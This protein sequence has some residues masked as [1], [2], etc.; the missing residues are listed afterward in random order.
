MPEDSRSGSKLKTSEK[1]MEEPG[2]DQGMRN[3]P[4]MKFY[5]RLAGNL[6]QSVLRARRTNIEDL[7]KTRKK[8][9]QEADLTTKEEEGT[10]RHYC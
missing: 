1:E 5:V 9:S 2:I 8:K 4:L 10:T 7:K 6:P 3:H